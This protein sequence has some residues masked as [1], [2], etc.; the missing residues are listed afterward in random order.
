[1]ADMGSLIVMGAIGKRYLRSGPGVNGGFNFR[2]LMVMYF[3]SLIFRAD[4]L[5]I[6]DLLLEFYYSDYLFYLVIIILCILYFDFVSVSPKGLYLAG[7]AC[8][9]YLCFG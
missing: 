8:C 6:L 5:I 3:Y 9:T 1:M 2:I 7:A 4:Q